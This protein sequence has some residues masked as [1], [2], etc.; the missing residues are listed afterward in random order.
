[1]RRPLAF[2]FLAYM[3]GIG[4]NYIFSPPAQVFAASVI[5]LSICLTLSAIMKGHKVLILILAAIII[6][7]IG[8]LVCYKEMTKKDSL[9]EYEGQKVTF[10]GTVTK[11]AEKSEDFHKL[12][13]K[14]GTNKYLV[15]V[16]GEGMTHHAISGSY[17][18]F[19]GEVEKPS[20]RRNPGSF[21]YKLY[22]MT[23]NIRSI[24]SCDVSQ[25]IITEPKFSQHPLEW[26]FNKITQLKSKFL[27]VT[28][29]YMSPESHGMINGMLFG[30]KDGIDEETYEAFQKN[31]IAHIL[32]VSGIHVG[33]V[34]AFIFM[35]MGRRINIG[36]A[37]AIFFFLFIYA[38]LSEFSPSVVRA[39]AMIS[40]HV[41]ANLLRRPYDLLTGICLAAFIMLIINPLS[42]LHVGFQLSFLAVTLLAFFIPL[43]KRYVGRKKL[44]GVYKERFSDN[45][46]GSLL[47]DKSDL[48]KKTVEVLTPLVIIQIGMAPFSMFVFNHFSIAGLILNIPIIF[49]AGLLIPV[50][51]CLIPIALTDLGIL[52]S[53]GLFMGT[54]FLDISLSAIIK[55]NHT[56]FSMKAS[57]L[58]VTSLPPWLLLMIYGFMF[59]FASESFRILR[60]RKRNVLSISIVFIIALMAVLCSF[61]SAGSLDKSDIVFIDVGQGD[62]IH[63]RTPS[64]KNVLIDGGGSL[65]FNVGKK[66]LLPYFLKNG[67]GK[68]DY[69]FVTHLH[70]DHFQ[71]VKELSEH[72]EIENLITYDGNRARP[73]DVTSGSGIDMDD[74]IFVGEGDRLII[75]D[76]IYMDI[77]YPYKRTMEEY[78]SALEQEEDENNNSLFMRLHYKDV[79]VLI[80]GDLDEAGE[81][82]IM[83]ELNN[84]AKDLK[85]TI[86]KVGHHGSKYST[87]DDFLDYV[88]PESA[89]IQVG[90]NNYGHPAPEVIEKLNNN[91]IIV[92]RNDTDGAIMIN[93]NGGHI[94]FDRMIKKE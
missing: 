48:K 85:S 67:V 68:L 73:E 3:L 44:M 18:E 42:L 15:H 49:M 71:G 35:L 13:V 91:N 59:F 61:T 83:A 77:L 60:N 27:T 41:L 76:D 22:L 21:D 50:G 16:Y 74:L 9:D 78:M 56:V 14:N 46:G 2:I 37:A 17:V 32:S 87:S 28:K 53:A 55:I 6:F 70:T 75:D 80:T 36:T 57:S 8:G 45:S 20:P 92:Y 5:F 4:A 89:V 12:T 11:S 66:T 19:T 72:M 90:K 38:F 30:N 64:G 63:V 88:N 84:P 81:R 10:S 69:V 79:S 25:V 31:G 86:L 33:I 52:T 34:Y 93:Y 23:L 54:K 40:I 58:S 26:S 47:I 39:A 43:S 65:D 82:L 7:N 29:G 1:M 24:I 62:G 51:I 94:T